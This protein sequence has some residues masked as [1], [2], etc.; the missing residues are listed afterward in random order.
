MNVII[1]NEERTRL[2]DRLKE[3]FGSANSL[4]W[5]EEL[6]IAKSLDL[7]GAEKDELSLLLVG[8]IGKVVRHGAWVN[9]EGM[10][11]VMEFFGVESIAFTEQYLEAVSECMVCFSTSFLYDMA[12]PLYNGRLYSGEEYIPNEYVRKML[13]KRGYSKDNLTEEFIEGLW[14]I[15]ELLFKLHS[16]K[17]RGLFKD[18]KEVE[19]Y[20]LLELL[21][22]SS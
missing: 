15:R 2:F 19:G 16:L 7:T 22:H 8:Y 5:G 1:S 14:Q 3:N 11:P 12:P 17:N 10:Q 13:L 6:N 18:L 20:Q 4:K 21:T 9:F